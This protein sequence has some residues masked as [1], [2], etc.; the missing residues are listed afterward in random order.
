MRGKTRVDGWATQTVDLDVGQPVVRED[1][2]F[3][4]GDHQLEGRTV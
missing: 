2:F 3:L 1:L 4:N